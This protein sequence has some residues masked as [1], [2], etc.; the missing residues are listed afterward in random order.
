MIGWL[1]PIVLLP[2][3]AL[4]G[5]SEEQ[6]RAVIAHELAHVRRLD[7]FVNLFQIRGRSA[8]FYHPAMWW[9]NRRI[10]GERELACDEVAVSMT[11]DRLDYAR[12]LAL[13]AEWKCPPVLAM[14]A[15]RAP[16]PT[17]ISAGAGAKAAA[18]R[19]SVL[20]GLGAGF[21]LLAATLGVVE[22]HAGR[23][24]THSCRPGQGGC[25]GG[26]MPDAHAGRAGGAVAAVHDGD[27]RTASR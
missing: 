11:G 13:M 1:R 22:T 19:G 24:S 17:R 26:G 7:A 2:V 8:A 16:L 6:L 9:L 4:T 21:V 10:R 15:N 27:T 14:A 5:L 3:Q 23:R 12:A 25:D 20:L 18:V